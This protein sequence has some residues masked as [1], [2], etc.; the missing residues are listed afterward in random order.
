MVN[1]TIYKFKPL[2]KWKLLL[3]IWQWWRLAE[4]QWNTWSKEKVVIDC[5]LAYDQPY[6]N[7]IYSGGT[8]KEA[9]TGG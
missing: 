6:R 8:K 7:V 1:K 2:L 4:L 9:D 3:T 5:A